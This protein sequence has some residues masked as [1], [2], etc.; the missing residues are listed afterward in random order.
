MEM[1]VKF[2]TLSHPDRIYNDI[3][4][5]EDAFPSFV[6][7]LVP[8]SCLRQARCGGGFWRGFDSISEKGAWGGGGDML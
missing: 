1:D 8:V 5:F 7:E 6:R 2:R 3:H 4:T